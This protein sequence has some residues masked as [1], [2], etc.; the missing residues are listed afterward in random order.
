MPVVDLPAPIIRAPERRPF[1]IPETETET[2]DMPFA[3][4]H[5]RP[6]PVELS[7]WLTLAAIAAALLAAII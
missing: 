7:I 1:R 4:N 2:E 3:V 5:D 6:E